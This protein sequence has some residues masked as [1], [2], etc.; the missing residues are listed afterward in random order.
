MLRAAV[1]VRLQGNQKDKQQHEKWKRPI[2]R[3]ES[4]VFNF[5]SKCTRVCVNY[6]DAS[7]IVTAYDFNINGDSVSLKRDK[8]T[9]KKADVVPRIIEGLPSY[10]PTKRKPQSRSSAMRPPCKRPP[11][12]EE[13]R[14]SP[15]P[16]LDRT[17]ATRMGV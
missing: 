14:A 8:P 17:V 5:E 11:S 15:T 10:L 6:Y 16:C 7:D 13:L 2:P 3:Q 1:P 12:C 9:P 4:G